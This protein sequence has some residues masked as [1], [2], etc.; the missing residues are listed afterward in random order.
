MLFASQDSWEKL[1]LVRCSPGRAFLDVDITPPPAENRLVCAGRLAAEKG[2]LVLAEAV[3]NLIGEGVDVSLTFVGDG[4]MR[5]D[6]ERSFADAGL[7]NRFTITG[8]VGSAEVADHIRS[9]RV[10]LQPSFAEG[11]PVSIMEALCLGRPVIAS[12]VAAVSE[13]VCPG[14][15]GWLVP[16]GS[17]D[18]L[19][20]A[21]AECLQ[22]TDAK[23]AEMGQRGAALVRAR[24][25][26]QTETSK[27]EDLIHRSVKAS[28]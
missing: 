18:D 17:V 19:S 6:I 20:R 13:L 15:T 7:E 26:V 21:I 16:P 12:N 11:L 24:H 1:A 14:E 27:L 8:Y 9:G 5:A 25:G 3:R 10:F 2:H 28:S 23:I 22:L 4:P